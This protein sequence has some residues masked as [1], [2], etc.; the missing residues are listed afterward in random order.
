MAKINKFANLYDKDGN[1]LRKAPLKN[2]TIPE[3][4]KMIDEYKGDKSSYEYRNLIYSLTDMYSKYGNP[5][6]KDLIERINEY[7]EQKRNNEASDKRRIRE[8]LEELSDEIDKNEAIKSDE[9]PSYNVDSNSEEYV[10]PIIEEDES[11]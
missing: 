1:L 10:E 5:H 7:A 4:E 2:V 11:K 3:L 8:S 6:E 9:V